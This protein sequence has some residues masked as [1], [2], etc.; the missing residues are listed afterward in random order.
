MT[1]TR[2]TTDQIEHDIDTE[3]AALAR[4]VRDLQDDFSPDAIMAT[5][6][7]S[8]RQV[9]GDVA[10]SLSET[11]RRNPVPS[12]LIGIGVAWLAASTASRSVGQDNGTAVH[13]RPYGAA[14][15]ALDGPRNGQARSED[16]GFIA[17]IRQAASGASERAA[18]RIDDLI[19][20]ITAGTEQMDAEARRRVV[21]AREAALTAHLKVEKALGQAA[22]RASQTA[23][24]HPLA[25][26][27]AAL[28]GG[29]ILGAILPGTEQENRMIGAHRDRLLD[30][31][32]RIYREERAKLEAASK[33]ALDETRSVVE[34]TLSGSRSN[35]STTAAE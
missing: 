6:S 5:L 26:G 22:N 27:G 18:N 9:S 23:R 16:D 15:P 33:A 31:A 20:G 19:D 14:D 13:A 35:G 32:D 11:V 1:D 30:A 34:D 24:S 17:K 3:R 10:T 7:D 25:A 21:A 2:T 8:L 29:A 4:A 28:L 12:A